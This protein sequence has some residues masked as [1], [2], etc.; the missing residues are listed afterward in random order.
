MRRSST[1][2]PSLGILLVAV[3]AL[4]GCRRDIEAESRAERETNATKVTADSTDD[5]SAAIVD[6]DFRFR[7]APPGPGW[8][9]LRERDARSLSPDAI[10]GALHDAGSYGVVIIERLPQTSLE[11][12]IELLWD[13]AL[14]GLVIESE[15][16]LE[17]R[18]LPAKRREFS[19]QVQGQTF[20]YVTTVFF[21]QEHLHQLMSWSSKPSD[22]PSRLAFHDAFEPLDGEIAVR[23][24]KR[25]PITHFDGVGWRIRDGRYESGL[26]GLRL[27]LPEGWRFIV[28]SELEQLETDAEIVVGHDLAS[29]L[30]AFTVER[31]PKP[32]LAALA[33]LTQQ[34]FLDGQSP[35]GEPLTLELAG[36]RLELRRYLMAPLEF[37]HGVHIGDEAVTAMMAWYPQ[38]FAESSAE[39]IDALLLGVETVPAS[40]RASLHEQLL[41]VPTRQRRFS[42]DRVFRAREFL[43]F[44]HQLRWSTPP[45]F[46]SVEDFDKALT[47]TPNTVLFATELELGVF[48]AIEVLQ[49][50]PDDDASN[51]LT[52]L[53]GGDELISRDTVVVDGLTVHRART[54][55]HSQDP[56]MN[57]AI[58][59]TRRGPKLF[60]TA[61]WSVNDSPA[62][63]AAMQAALAG[64]DYVPALERT[65]LVGRLFTDTL[66]GY[67]FE[68]PVGFAGPPKVHNQGLSQV[69]AWAKGNQELVSLAIAGASDDEEWMTSF[70]EQI[71]RDSVG[72]NTSLGKPERS[73]GL[74]GGHPARQ[75]TW[76]IAGT[77]MIAQ[78]LVREPHVY[79][80]LYKNLSEAQR[81][82][83]QASWTML[84]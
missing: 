72:A 29:I 10:A 41:G 75:L 39:L 7:L 56:P 79:C 60:S 28:G 71:L 67:S 68:I 53:I 27:R 81:K 24:V 83:V 38:A 6:E 62:S 33:R 15:Q 42:T 21:R 54:I 44:A 35:T 3:L 61:A 76:S 19:A 65:Q 8:K 5:A 70:S 20:Y 26:S 9:L 13:D 48:V 14:P 64:L 12:A 51:L 66:H 77:H 16:D 18:G 50:E 22:R 69:S 2:L 49:A 32:R 34:N 55:D 52:D 40:E 31:A 59:V 46:W 45:G 37:L 30:V 84:E 17:F 43:D 58:A 82:T 4:V 1:R 63:L 11:Q 36:Q 57:Y 73:D 78:I 25:E 80:M 23:Q 47:H 74:L